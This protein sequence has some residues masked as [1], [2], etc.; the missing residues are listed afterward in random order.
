[1]SLIGNPAIAGHSGW[2][3]FPGLVRFAHPPIG[4]VVRGPRLRHVARNRWQP[5][6]P[7][8]YIPLGPDLSPQIAQYT[9]TNTQTI[10]RRKRKTYKKKCCQW[11][12]GKKRCSPNY[13][14]KRRR[15][16]RKRFYW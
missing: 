4:G 11:I 12:K 16:Y 6:N 5:Y 14:P 8:P 7:Q 2:N 10:R 1:M 9:G 15:I 13:C 3:R